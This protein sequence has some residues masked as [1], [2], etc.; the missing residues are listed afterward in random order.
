TASSNPRDLLTQGAVIARVA[1]G[2]PAAAAGLRVGDV[3]LREG[4]RAVR[5]PYDWDAALLDLRV[6]SPA[7]LHV[8][9]GSREFDVNVKVS[10]LPDVSAPKVQVLKEL[11]LV[12]VT[13]AIRAERN[14]RAQ[15]G[16]LIY[17]VSQRVADDLGIQPGDVIVRIN[18]TPIRTAQD[19][20]RA[21]N[22]YASRGYMRMWVEHQGQL[23]FTDF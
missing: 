10:D 12:T 21:I 23:Y 5:N 14:L 19:V 13:P 8:K 16:A 1:P 4:N 22:A 17:N 15:S 3:I 6:G 20:S 9:R 7:Q 11:E 2:S 18:N